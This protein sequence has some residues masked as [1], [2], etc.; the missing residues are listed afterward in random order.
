MNIYDN[1]KGF[2][3]AGIASGIK[4]SGKLDLG[5]ICSD[6]PATCAGV[7]TQ[8][9]VV[10][11]PITVT[12]PRI[13]SGQCQAILVNSGNAN[14]CTGQAGITVAQEMGALVAKQ[15]RVPVELVAVASTGVIGKQ[16]PIGP[17]LGG[18]PQLV[19]QLDSEAAQLTAESMMTT[20]CYSKIAS[21]QGKVDGQGYRILGLA[22]GA[23][24][25]HPNMATMLG[26]VMTDAHLPAER[27]DRALRQAVDRSFNVITV[28]ADTSTNDMVLLLANGAAGVNIAADSDAEA[29]FCQHLERV[30][31]DL[32]KMIVRDGEGATKLVEIRV[33]GAVDDQQARIAARSVA[34]S[35]LVKTAFFGEDANWGRI[36]AAVGYSGVQI[37]QERIDIS[38]DGVPVTVNGLSSGQE[39]EDKATAVLK[40][41]EFVVTVELHQGE[42]AASYYTS[43]LTYDYIRIN[44]DY[45]S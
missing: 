45:R 18:I 8:N 25:I 11:A 12:R 27:L 29:E 2:R 36:I 19:K 39:L 35:S 7:F 4:S 1:P 13:A 23:G 6:A 5:L 14:A 17:L 22:K 30:L 16:L 20:D 24:M 21:A 34:T 15:L 26:F 43:D 32:A 9:Q 10:A 41:G 37:D 38:F 44:A 40:Q 3:F 31:V 42:G 33:T 28:D